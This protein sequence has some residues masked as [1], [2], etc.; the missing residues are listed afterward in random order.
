MNNARNPKTYPK[1]LIYKPAPSQ[2]VQQSDP[3]PHSNEI[4]QGN[5][6][7]DVEKSHAICI[8]IQK[9]G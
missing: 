6:D 1:F 2:R 3:K 4:I 5:V 9:L 7:S 8:Y